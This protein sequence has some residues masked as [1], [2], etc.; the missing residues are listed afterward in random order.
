MRVSADALGFQL[1]FVVEPRQRP[2]ASPSLL[3][4][5]GARLRQVLRGSRDREGLADLSDATLADIGVRPEDVPGRRR[6]DPL[7]DTARCCM[8]IPFWP[9][10]TFDWTDD[11]AR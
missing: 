11:R 3:A 6:G 8:H 7:L 1:S 9:G 10:V 2:A 4:R 5:F